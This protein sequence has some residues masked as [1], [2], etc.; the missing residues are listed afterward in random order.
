MSFIDIIATPEGR[1]MLGYCV[2]VFI[3]MA[4]VIFMAGMTYQY[5]R[6]D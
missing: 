5:V 1:Y 2:T 4:I 6:N 3:P